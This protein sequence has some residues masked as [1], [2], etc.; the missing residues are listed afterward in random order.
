MDGAGVR[1]GGIH[2]ARRG[3][4]TPQTPDDKVTVTMELDDKTRAVVK[5]DSVASIQT[6]GLLGDEYV[7]VSFGS[8]TRRRFRMGTRSPANP[9]SKCRTY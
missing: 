2:M 3:N 6:E 9:H 1:V 7:D 8:K 5:K 4:P